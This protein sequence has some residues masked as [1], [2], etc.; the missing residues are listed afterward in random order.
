MPRPPLDYFR[1]LAT[2]PALPCWGLGLTAAGFTRVPAGSAYPPARHPTDHHLDW[3]HGRVLDTL[4]I[5]LIREGYGSFESEATGRRAIEPG[6]AFVIVPKTWHRYRPDPATGWTES[7]IEVQGPVV[8]NLLRAKVFSASAAVRKIEPAAGLEEA[9]ELVH[10]QARTAGPGFSPELAAAA[11]VVLAAWDKAA[12]IQPERS[13]I[14]RAVAEAERHLAEHLSEP[15]DLPALARRLG[16]GYSHF[17]RA[18]RAHTGFA[19]WQY[20]LHLRVSRARRLLVSS[21]ATLDELAVRLGFSS[22]FHLSSTFKRTYGVAPEH[23][24]KQYRRPAGAR[25]EA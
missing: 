15:I 8:E 16:I 18:F 7:W 13:R 9:L 2:G 1:Y 3:E 10:E 4:Q 14:T 23:W 21:D 6:T 20:V 5:V 17:R 22:G 19:P 11:L 12:R 24:R 25:T